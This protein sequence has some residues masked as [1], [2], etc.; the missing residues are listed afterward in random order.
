MGGATPRACRDRRDAA[1]RFATFCHGSIFAPRVR[2]CLGS[3]TRCVSVCAL[4]I[5][6]Q[7]VDVCL[8]QRD[9]CK[10]DHHHGHMPLCGCAHTSS[11]PRT[12]CWWGTPAPARPCWPL[13]WAWLPAR[14]GV[15]SAS[16]PWRRWPTNCSRRAPARLHMGQGRPAPLRSRVAVPRS[17]EDG[18]L[19][20]RCPHPGSSGHLSRQLRRRKG[21]RN[22]SSE[23]SLLA[24][25]AR[26]D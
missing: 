4:R 3:R 20:H 18:G 15:Q 25:G 16:P 13:H 11:A 6:L 17:D 19:P 10:R 23:P 8:S 21:C 12:S 1:D 24:L 22:P 9:A 5:S 14:R 2:Q 26:P 7:A